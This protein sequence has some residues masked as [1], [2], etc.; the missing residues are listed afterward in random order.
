MQ[1]CAGEGR[2]RGKLGVPTPHPGAPEAGL[3]VPTHARGCDKLCWV[4]DGFC[5]CK[6]LQ[7]LRDR[8]NCSGWSSK[9]S[10]AAFSRVVEGGKKP[11]RVLSPAEL[12]SLVVLSIKAGCGKA[13]QKCK[14]QLLLGWQ[15]GG[16]DTGHGIDSR[17]R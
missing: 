10:N 17:G 14:S 1:D 4:P 15:P 13:L 2:D 7:G 5:L 9:C 11:P 16:G 8:K 3:A 6:D 12:G